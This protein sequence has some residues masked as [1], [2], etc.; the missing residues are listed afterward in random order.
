[1]DIESRLIISG[2]SMKLRPR[3]RNFVALVRSGNV[4]YAAKYYL[5]RI[6]LH[7][8]TILKTASLDLVY[9]RRLLGGD[10]PTRFASFGARA[11]HHTSYEILDLIFATAVTRSND[12]FVGSGNGR[13]IIYWL[14]HNY[15]RR[16][17]GLEIDPTIESRTAKQF[18]RYPQVQII[19]GDA[20]NN[21]PTDATFF[22]LYNPFDEAKVIELERRLAVLSD[23]HPIRIVYYNPNFLSVFPADRW[24]STV[25]P[26]DGRL[27]HGTLKTFCF[28]VAI[29]DRALPTTATPLEADCAET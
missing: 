11:V 2:W 17:V 13:V 12:V 28:P 21:L 5:G 3:I 19:A 7:P 24:H 27:D 15:G 9:A 10:A 29:L 4:R 26:L 14:H 25:V 23:Q 20:I 8:A 18:R 6:R 22:Y 16:I 1:M